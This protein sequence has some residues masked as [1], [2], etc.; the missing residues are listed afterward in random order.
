MVINLDD[1]SF[2]TYDTDSAYFSK[3]NERFLDGCYEVGT[4]AFQDAMPHRSAEEIGKV[5]GD[6]LTYLARLADPSLKVREGLA[7]PDQSFA[8]PTLSVAIH[9]FGSTGQKV[10]GYAFSA[11]NTSGSSETV[12]QAKMLSEFKKY[13]CLSTIVVDPNFQRRGIG[14]TLTMAAM[15]QANWLQPASAYTWPE[16]TT[17][18]TGLLTAV[19]FNK[20]GE[21]PVDVF[22]NGKPIRQDTLQAKHA[23]LIATRIVAAYA[24]TGH[25]AN[26]KQILDDQM[27]K[28]RRPHDANRDFF[29]RHH[30]K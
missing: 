7:N 3:L 29:L 4:V 9:K 2:R 11:D 23:F 26:L 1:I 15:A 28:T 30:S 19:G 27:P 18:G 22:R 21:Q 24:S 8:D 13:R 25:P 6:R 12:R 20:T 10:V 16:E 17:A 14:V 5:M